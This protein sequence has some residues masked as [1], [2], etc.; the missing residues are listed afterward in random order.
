MR[1]KADIGVIDI[2]VHI[3][4]WVVLSII[5]FGIALFFAPYSFAKFIINRS[6][7]ID[8]NGT[9]KQLRCNTDIFGNV[10]HVILWM[11]ISIITFGLGYLFYFF[12]VW[13]YSL[14]NTT[15]D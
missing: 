7:L 5:T 13:N 2:I 9:E 15:I 10:G 4:I 11:I 6:K 8:D 3:I 1:L 12:K 14:N